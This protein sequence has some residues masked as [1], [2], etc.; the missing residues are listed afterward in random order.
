M[1]EENPERAIVF[2]RMKHETKRLAK[3]LEDHGGIKAGYL[4]GNMSQNARNTG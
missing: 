1:Q 2:T 4:N 3:K